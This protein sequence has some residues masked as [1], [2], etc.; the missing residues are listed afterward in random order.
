MDARPSLWVRLATLMLMTG[1][2]AGVEEKLGA[3]EKALQSADP[4]ARTRDLLGQIAAVRAVL[5]ILRYQSEEGFVQSQRALEYL[6][7]DNVPSRSRALWTLGYSHQLQGNRAAALEVFTEALKQASGTAYYTILILASLGQ[8][9]ESGNQ[10]V[11]AAQTYRRSLELFG[12]QEPPNASEEYVGLGRICYEWNDLDAA[13]R[14]GQLSLELSRRYDP[15]IDRF[16]GA[17]VLLARVK[18]ALGK[19][20]DAAEMLG[21]VAGIVRQRS[22]VQRL[23]EVAAAQVLAWLRQGKVAEAAVLAKEHDLPLSQARVALAQGDPAVALA[24]LEPVRRQAEARDWADERLRAMILRS[25]ALHAGGDIDNAVQLLG[26]ALAMA[27]PAGFVRSFLDEGAPMAGLL[28]EAARRGVM[29]DYTRKLLSAFEA[30]ARG[31]VAKT[32]SPVGPSLV[33]ALSE[34]ELDI[35]KLVAKGL[36]NQEISQRLFLALS[37]VKGHNR[38]LFGKLHVQNRTEA[39]ARARE[40]GLL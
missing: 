3:A 26:E 7:P 18:L 12:D 9:Q 14:Y 31:E 37:T 25:L 32:R 24:A 34:R 19:A 29:P 6:R 36:S 4:D 28:A 15:A 2:T 40:L 17:E 11:E 35:L 21:R 38:V 23:P 1:Q 13:E 22:F 16:V 33:E 27:E 8:L 39:V 20:A 30:E 10:L 5:A